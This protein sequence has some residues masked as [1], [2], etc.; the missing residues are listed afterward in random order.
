MFPILLTFL[1]IRPFISSLAFPYVNTIYSI[2]SVIF[3]G[4]Y[5]FY[6]K[7]VLPKAVIFPVILFF[8]ALFV[9][10]LFSQNKLNSLPEVYNYVAGILLFFIAASLPEENKRLLIGIIILSGLV[11]S[12][13]AL[14]QFFF[15]FTRMLNY[16]LNNDLALPFVVECLQRKRVFLPFATPNVLGGYLALVLPLA[17]GKK[18][19]FILPISAALL[20]TKSL[21]ALFALCCALIIYSRMSGRLKKEIFI[22]FIGLFIVAAAVFISRSAAQNEHTLPMFSTVMRLNYW[23]ETFEIIRAHPF[24]G[25]GPGNLNLVMSRYSHNS[26]LQIWA[27]MGTMGLI[28]FI[29][30]VSAVLRSCFINLKNPLYKSRIAALVAAILVFLIHNF[31]DFTFFLPEVVFAWW[32]ILGSGLVNESR[33]KGC[34]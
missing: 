13:F 1:F 20:L 22:Y 10:V 16:V 3:L 4:A 8:L 32:A 14:Y 26:Y 34:D 21:G 33:E 24:A 15:G 6:K 12:F 9:S 28:S 25:V 29:W 27:E 23:Q 5:V 18:S 2:A 11:I 31:L 30:I 17:I 19:W 7:P